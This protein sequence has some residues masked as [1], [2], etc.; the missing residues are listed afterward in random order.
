M[1]K[2][3]A[4]FADGTWN[5]PGQDDN[6]DGIPDPT[7]VFRLFDNL[8]GD[9]TPESKLL[10]DEQ[11]Q[12]ALGPDGLP[13]QISKY[14]HGVGDSRNVIHKIIG[15]GFGA[16]LIN[17]IV[18]G[19][20]FISRSYEPGDSIYIVGFS[21]GAYTAR[22]LGGMICSVGLLDKQRHAGLE[23]RE[24]A[25][26]LGISAWTRYRRAAGKT[27][28]FLEFVKFRS[29]VQ[30]SEDDFLKDVEIEAVGVWD[31]VGALGIP[32]YTRGEGRTDEFQFTDTKLS[33]KVHHGFHAVSIDERRAD[34]VPTLWEPRTNISE[35]WFAGAHADVGGGYSGRQLS[36]I[37]LLWM[38][39][40]L[41][42]AKL[43][44]GEGLHDA[45]TPDPLGDSHA[46][47][48]D[49]PWKHLPF[50]NRT[51]PKGA[52]LHESVDRRRTNDP[53]YV[54]EAL[55]QFLRESQTLSG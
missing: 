45:L 29:G 42:A 15:G 51:I 33:A 11:E 25:Y 36:D 19:Y 41:K 34:F 50:Q 14:L 30:L 8:E 37:A 55:M 52:V 5:G 49:D 44:I 28:T 20:T 23:D 47:W 21:R 35:V 43:L 31:T 18:R 3:I 53:R 13:I 17:R 46:P 16:G 22:A 32:E 24:N 4:F 48:D 54:P 12:I 9:D 6:N 26:R 40:Q 1:S 2:N 27:G 38:A 10:Q 7:N 39:E